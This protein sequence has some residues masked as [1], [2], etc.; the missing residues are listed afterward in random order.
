MRALPCPR[1]LAEVAGDAQR[2][3]QGPDRGRIVPGRPPHVTQDGQGAGL[4][5]L[6]AE[7]A[8]DA[9]RFLEV[10]GR[11]RVVVCQPPHMP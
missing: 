2:L 6:V 11:A 8:A 3:F 7:V 4:A 5:G 10:P 1:P 9:Q